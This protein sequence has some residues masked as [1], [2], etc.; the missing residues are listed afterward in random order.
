[1]ESSY[2]KPEYTTEVTVVDGKYAA[3]FKVEILSAVEESRHRQDPLIFPCLRITTFNTYDDAD[4]IRIR[5]REYRVDDVSRW[6]QYEQGEPRWGRDHRTYGDRGYINE[7]GGTVEWSTPTRKLLEGLVQRAREVFV[8]EHPDWTRRSFQRRLTWMIRSEEQK[9]TQARD[10]ARK[11]DA[12][13]AELRAE[14]E[15]L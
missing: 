8:D 7:R 9:A 15:A 4:V 3:T 5:G 13:A 6:E 10:E 14:L 11:H 2:T 1:M 12:V